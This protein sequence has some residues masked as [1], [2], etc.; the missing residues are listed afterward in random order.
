MITFA[1]MF[2]TAPRTNVSERGFVGSYGRYDRRNCA[3][4]YEANALASRSRRLR[5]DL[6][7][8]SS[9][10]R[11]SLSTRGLEHV[12]QASFPLPG[13]RR[14]YIIGLPLGALRT[15]AKNDRRTA[16][17][18]GIDRCARGLRAWNEEG[19]AGGLSKERKTK[20]RWHIGVS[21][22]ILGICATLLPGC[23][24][25]GGTAPEQG[26]KWSA[27][28]GLNQVVNA[29]TIYNGDLIAGG[30]F[31]Q[32]GD[33]SVNFIARW[34]GI[35]WHPLAGGVIYEQLGA[36]RV[37]GLGV[38]DGK[39]IVGGY[40]SKAGEVPA[41]NIAQWDGSSWSALGAGID[42]VGF[43]EGPYTF[44]AYGG[45]LIVGGDFE[46]AGGLTVNHIARWDGTSWHSVGGG[47]SGGGLPVTG[48]CV[49][50][51][52]VSGGRLIVGGSFTKAGEV[53]VNNI[54][55]WDGSSWTALGS[56]TTGGRHGTVY[57][58]VLLEGNLVI[59]GDFTQAGDTPAGRVALWD[60]SSWSAL[61]SGMSDDVACLSIYDGNLVAAGAFDGLSTSSI[62]RWDGTSWKPIDGGVAGG[63]FGIPVVNDLVVLDESLIA[64]G[65]FTSAGGITV[66]N[67]ASWED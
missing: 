32:A 22:I 18:S 3:W 36:G 23:G 55:A 38:Y 10:P 62:A 57:D 33:V 34:D 58:Q 1:D 11:L 50:C 47:V 53:D 37:A 61:G 52:G 19:I 67:I 39:L 65:N 64:G 63:L 2:R 15:L 30:N 45:D 56:G 25:D 5:Y 29:M 54:A 7:C 49:R 27:L 16:G 44:V 46:K 6:D 24:D 48:T 43:L 12:A 28:P 14:I 20:M 13:L 17:G 51:L 35:S 42:T 4:T 9:L 26:G 60:G 41:D 21:L 31:T 40:F 8:T 66:G 59:G